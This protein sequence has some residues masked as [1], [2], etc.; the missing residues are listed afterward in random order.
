MSQNPSDTNFPTSQLPNFPAPH[1]NRLE[2]LDSIRGLACVAVLL[3]HTAGI[4]NWD[5]S[6]T[7][8]PLINN[9]FDGRSAVTIFFVLS[10]FV[11]SLKHVGKSEKPV[12]LIPFYTRRLCR[13]WI[14]WFGF[15]LLSLAAKRY[16]FDLPDLEDVGIS[17][18]PEFQTIWSLDSSWIEYLRQTTYSLHDSRKLL[19][20]QD[21]SLGVELRASLIIPF[22]ILASR[23]SNF[24]VIILAVLALVIKPTTGCYYTSFCLGVLAA[25]IHS[26][27]PLSFAERSNLH[28]VLFLSGLLLYQIRWAAATP[29]VGFWELGETTIWIASSLG[30]TLMIFIAAHSKYIKKILMT[31]SLIFLGKISFSLYLSQVIVILTLGPWSIYLLAKCGIF[32]QIMIQLMT[33]TIVAVIS[34][35]FAWLGEKKFEQPSIHLG[36]LS[37]RILEKIEFV[38]KIRV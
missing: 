9:I 20:P 37:S 7:R 24:F 26:A 5:I 6:Y 13:I 35:F 34:V 3:G 12:T 25:N 15:F 33:I 18:T 14:P 2:G 31:K 1:S 19:L 22:I 8:W 4:A 11:L 29:W 36:R 30:C 17:L 28:F 16:F 38:R 23:K 21:W 32:S 10:G 27:I